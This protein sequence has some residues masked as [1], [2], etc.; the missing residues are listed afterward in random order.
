MM[1][2]EMARALNAGLGLANTNNNTSERRQES[3]SPAHVL[4]PPIA[5]SGSSLP[6]EGSFEQFLAN[7]QN[8]LRTIL[9]EEPTSVASQDANVSSEP[10]TDV[11]EQPQE[12]EPER[13]VSRPPTPIPSTEADHSE[14]HADDDDEPPPLTGDLESD[15]DESFHDADGAGSDDDSDHQT[16]TDHPP[17]IPTPIP[18]SFPQDQPAHT[19]PAGHRRRERPAINLW[20]IYRFDPIP[21]THTQGQAAF[22]PRPSSTGLTAVHETGS[23]ASA[24]G[25]SSP[26]RSAGPDSPRPSLTDS[27]IPSVHANIV[28]PVI[29]V[30]LQSVDVIDPDEPEDEAMHTHPRPSSP[31]DQTDPTEDSAERPT[32]PRG[33]RWPSRAANALRTWRPGRR[34]SRTGRNADGSGSRTFLIYVI[35]GYYPPNHHMVTGSDNLDSYEALWEL[36][37]LL[38]QVKPPTATR[39]DIDKSGLQIV[40]ASELARLEEEGRVASNCVDRCLVCLDEYEPDSDLRLMSCRHAF[41]KDCVDKWLQVGRNNCPACRTM[42]VNVSGD[43][44]PTTPEPTVT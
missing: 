17:R 13:V 44:P 10:P 3:T 36:A 9:S 38:G 28:V 4:F 40:K 33:R 26:T 21:A 12:H 43:P 19:D 22:S 11:E 31:T 20:R 42:G 16:I 39:E 18:N 35:G 14:E 25:P 8:D 34:G 5:D 27:P 30:G 23:E 2:A 7:L 41:H 37:E 6:P 15:S 29:V 1:L 32:T 24:S